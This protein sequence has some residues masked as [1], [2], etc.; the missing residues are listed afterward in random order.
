VAR[1]LCQLVLLRL[2]VGDVLEGLVVG[3][4]GLLA[5]EFGGGGVGQGQVQLLLGLLDREDGTALSQGSV[6]QRVLIV[7]ELVLSVDAGLREGDLRLA[8]VV[9]GLLEGLLG[10]DELLVGL[11]HRLDRR[12]LSVAERHGGAGHLLRR[13]IRLLGRGDLLSRHLT[14]G[15]PRRLLHGVEV[16]EGLGDAD[17]APHDGPSAR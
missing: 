8:L 9:L 3:E 10:L 1:G 12:H 2:Q 14:S 6:G 17:E 15:L 7:V 16:T 4:L 5:L 13:A 11:L